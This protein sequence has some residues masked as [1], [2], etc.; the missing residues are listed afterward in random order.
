M[1]D[2]I[3]TGERL[4]TFLKTKRIKQTAL[5]EVIGTSR[6]YIS[7]L[8]K[9]KSKPSGNFLNSL[10]EKYP[11]LNINWLLTG[12]GSMFL[13]KENAELLV[14]EDAADYEPPDKKASARH[15]TLDELSRVIQDLQAEVLELR[16]RV[17]RLE[18]RDGVQD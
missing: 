5:A 14:Q 13:Q 17:R 8:T 4:K 2:K 7:L 10:T 6:S 16:S 9:D 15:I 3:S 12:N 1:T 11:E 18:R